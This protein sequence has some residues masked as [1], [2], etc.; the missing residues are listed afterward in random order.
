MG[1]RKSPREKDVDEQFAVPPP[2]YELDDPSDI[3]EHP[4]CTQ[5]SIDRHQSLIET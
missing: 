5:S 3:T 4:L 2:M 1:E